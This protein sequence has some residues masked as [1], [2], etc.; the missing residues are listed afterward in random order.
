MTILGTY[1]KK[2][3]QRIEV[4][5][6]LGDE[7]SIPIF[8]LPTLLPHGAQKTFQKAAEC[9]LPQPIVFQENSNRRSVLLTTI[10]MIYPRPRL[11][12]SFSHSCTLI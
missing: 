4:S 9:A 12:H 5:F 7:N 2:S 3:F 11:D 8:I 10:F 6:V 1:V